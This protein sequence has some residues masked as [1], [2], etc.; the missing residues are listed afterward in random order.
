[1]KR[2]GDNEGRREG[3]KVRMKKAYTKHQRPGKEGGI[4]NVAR[5][6]HDSKEVRKGGKD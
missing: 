1:M 4:R 6:L 2:R 3:R 5:R